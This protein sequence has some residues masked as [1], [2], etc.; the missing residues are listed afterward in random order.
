MTSW[1]K[2]ILF[3]LIIFLLFLPMIQ[4]NTGI[5]K[6]RK[7]TGVVESGSFPRFSLEAWMSGDFQ[8]K[9]EAI[10]EQKIGFR[11]FLVRFKN[12]AQYSLFKKANATGVVVG[13]SGYLYEFD[14]IRAFYGGDY[15]GEW[16][17]D[18][19]FRRTALV[20]DTLQAL[21]IELAI[22][23]EPGKASYYPEFIPNSLRRVSSSKT[24]Y[25]EIIRQT[26]SRDLS[27]LD[28]N[29]WFM[30]EKDVA[31]FP[32]FP[33]GGIHWSNSAMLNAVDTLLRFA[34]QLTSFPIPKMHVSRGEVTNQLRDTDN[35]LVDIINLLIEPKS[36][37]MHYPTFRF[38][39][40]P[41]TVKPK[42][43]AISDSF[44]F[45]ILNAGIPSQAFANSAFW[46]Y[47]KKIY[48]DTWTAAKDTSMIDFQGEVEK[49]NLILLM[50]TERFY[51]K[52]AWNF[53]ETLYRIYY[54][55][56]I[57]DTYY[58]YHTKIISD[59]QWFDLVAKDALNR[60]VPVSEALMDHSKYQLWQDEL[61]GTVIKDVAYYILKIK[62]DPN[63]LAQIQ[64]KSQ[65]NGIPLEEQ[66]ELDARWMVQND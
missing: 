48:P 38:D 11:P 28:L 53:I 15:L 19:K 20:R 7:L 49:M 39:Q 12:Q 43:L 59:Y 63:W 16:F 27:L 21:G 33:K 60:K 50:I 66:I 55:E 51:Y 56:D 9:F 54:P 22:V 61:N 36:E 29:A 10:L 64:E 30:K 58:S 41:D 2:D 26:S 42:V 4:Q 45:N 5:I 3:I 13:K 34:D 57:Q 32:H 35:D 1:K 6:L 14:Y 47:S 52:F 40:L 23:L 17:W 31:E 65:K 44:F 8:N 24:N 37:A 46:Y 25:N 62:K 18:E